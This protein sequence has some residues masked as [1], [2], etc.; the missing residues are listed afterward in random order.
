MNLTPFPILGLS[1]GIAAGKSFVATRLASHGWSV[2]DADALA[3]EVVSSGSEG[4]KE[5]VA[6]FGPDCLRPDGTL[7]RVWMASRVF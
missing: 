3:R 7:D 6:A 1:G 2:I 5:V 4:L